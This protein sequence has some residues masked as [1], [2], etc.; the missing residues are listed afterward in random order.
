MKRL[1]PVIF[2]VM[3]IIVE[4]IGS[5]CNRRYWFRKKVKMDTDTTSQMDKDYKIVW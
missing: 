5:S 4:L 3:I 1:L 2:I